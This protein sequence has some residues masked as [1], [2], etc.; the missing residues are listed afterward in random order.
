M[1]VMARTK[2]RVRWYLGGWEAPAAEGD[3]HHN[4]KGD[5]QME[6]KGLGG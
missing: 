5:S 1:G 3:V 4:L 2:L 6:A